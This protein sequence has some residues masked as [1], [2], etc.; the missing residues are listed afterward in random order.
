MFPDTQHALIVSCGPPSLIQIEREFGTACIGTPLI[1]AFD[2][3]LLIPVKD[4]P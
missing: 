4:F 2:S 1:G 3:L